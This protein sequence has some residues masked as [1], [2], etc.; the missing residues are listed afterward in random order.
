[1]V[2]TEKTRTKKRPA[3]NLSEC[4]L[5]ALCVDSC[6][7]DALVMTDYIE[8]SAFDS[9]EMIIYQEEEEG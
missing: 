1:M 9:K 3:I 4:I 7:Y 6:R 8:L 5:C 2:P